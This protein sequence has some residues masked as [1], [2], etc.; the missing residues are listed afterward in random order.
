MGSWQDFLVYPL[1][2]V[3]QLAD[4]PPDPV[5]VW[6]FEESLTQPLLHAF[7]SLSRQQQEEIRRIILEAFQWAISHM[8]ASS[9]NL[10]DPAVNPTDSGCDFQ[11]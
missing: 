9:I 10:L 2:Y 5:K 6:S 3:Y 8:D 4:S 7:L 11:I 1:Y